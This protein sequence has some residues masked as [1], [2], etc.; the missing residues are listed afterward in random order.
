MRRCDESDSASD[1]EAAEA[2]DAAA[3]DFSSGFE[4]VLLSSSEDED[5]VSE[6]EDAV[7]GDARPLHQRG[8]LDCP[9]PSSDSGPLSD[10]EAAEVRAS[11][12]PQLAPRWQSVSP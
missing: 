12:A 1:A 10:A 8:P 11:C 3:E 9:S 4:S 7:V 6:E 5:A 2:A